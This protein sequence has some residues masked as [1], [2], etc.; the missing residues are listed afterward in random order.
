MLELTQKTLDNIKKYLLRQQK[1]I[2]ENLKEVEKDD[3]VEESSLVET[4]EPG[5][6]SWLA[7]GH[8]RAQA[9]MLQLKNMGADIS[10]AL[11]KIK[12]GSYGKCQKCGHYIEVRRL[13]AM[14]SAKYCLSCSQK[15]GK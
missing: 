13:L 4:S 1:Q 9:L 10:E 5:T 6:E 15:I 14:P 8:N 7:E 3:P 11:S 2:S 12:L